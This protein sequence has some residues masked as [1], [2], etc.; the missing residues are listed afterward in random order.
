MLALILWLLGIPLV[1]FAIQEPVLADVLKDWPWWVTWPACLLWPLSV[2][3]IGGLT[4]IGW[5]VDKRS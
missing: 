4:A 1:R 2:V 3:A 5:V